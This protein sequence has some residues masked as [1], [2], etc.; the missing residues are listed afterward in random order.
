V[1]R[2]HD[3][4]ARLF[5]LAT[6][7][8]V[9]PFTAQEQDVLR[10]NILAD[11]RNIY[12]DFDVTFTETRPSS[13][14]YESLV[15]GLPTPQAGLL[16]LAD[17]IDL[18]NQSRNDVARIYTANFAGIVNEFDGANQRD[19][20]LAQLSRALAG[21][22]AH[23]LAHN[24]GIEHCD[25][26]ACHGIGPANY[27][28]T[29]GLQN[30]QIIATGGTGLNEIGRESARSFS[31]WERVKLA[32]AE[33]LLADAP[34]VLA[35]Q[36]ISYDALGMARDVSLTPLSVAD[37]SSA[38]VIGAITHANE[39]DYFSFTLIAGQTLTA[40]VHSETIIGT[41]YDSVDS[42]LSLIGPG[43]ETLFADNDIEY[44]RN[45]FNSG[46]GSDLYSRDTFFV[47]IPVTQNGVYTLAVSGVGG[48]T[49]GYELLVA[50]RQAVII[51]ESS[52]GWLGL[53]GF[54]LGTATFWRR[55]W[56][57]LSP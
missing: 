29:G 57:H 5:E 17:R 20:Q 16:G 37:A 41:V 25:C 47:N 26:Y 7:A 4:D 42:F 19:V 34:P 27:A 44:N 45:V 56:R 51:P 52:T 24:F 3:F 18:R 40:R 30:T 36:A 11:L 48:D 32:Y 46:L 8:T 38:F 28:N 22:A 54:L 2:L 21:T 1:A 23:E 31:F 39:I 6:S 33:G 9:T 49:G 50:T 14:D 53:G 13:G 35:E 43:G 12:A 55:L 10:A 15:W